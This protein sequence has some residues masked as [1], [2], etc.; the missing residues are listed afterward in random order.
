MFKKERQ[1]IEFLEKHAYLIILVIATILAVLMR[2]YGR[3]MRSGDYDIYLV[4]WFNDIKANGGFMALRNQVGD[5]NIAYQTVI[6]FL[7]GLPMDPLYSYKIVSIVFDFVLAAGTGILAC[8]VKYGKFSIKLFTAAYGLVLFLPAIFINSAFWAQCDSIYVSFIVLGLY[9][10]RKERFVIGF[11]FM[12][13]SLAFKLQMIF[14]LPF[15]I[16]LY[17]SNKKFSFTHILWIPVTLYLSTIPALVVGRKWTAFYDIYAN[18][19]NTYNEMTLNVPNFWWVSGGF[20]EYLKMPAIIMAVMILGFGLLFIIKYKVKLTDNRNY[21]LIAA[22]SVWTCLNF[23]PAMHERY[24][25]P[26]LILLLIMALYDLKRYAKYFVFMA[27]ILVIVYGRFLFGT[28]FDFTIASLSF[29]AFYAYFSY[30]VFV[31]CRGK[32]PDEGEKRSSGSGIR[33][34][35]RGRDFIY[36]E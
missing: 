8:D 11:L 30:E 31:T 22:W 36:K 21:L 14:I 29:N 18:Q 19:T 25:V 3:D 13:L 35:L 20:Y 15:I 33:V 5:Y 17:V 24:L 2:W 34:R 28:N 26:L 1:L 23:L 10:I 16:Y 6:A 27:M 4:N 9:F 12:G 7:T 32:A